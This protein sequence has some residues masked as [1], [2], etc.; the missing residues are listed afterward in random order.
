M[1][2][3]KSKINKEKIENIISKLE[4]NKANENHNINKSESFFKIDSIKI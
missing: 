3:L 1:H 2:V 4:K